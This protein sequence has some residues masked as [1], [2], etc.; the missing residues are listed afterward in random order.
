MKNPVAFLRLV[1]L[2][3]GISY[4]VLLGIAMP[5][6][7][8]AGRPQAVQVVGAIHGALFVVFGLALLR[9]WVATRWSIHR[10]ALVF[11]ASFIPFAPFWME[12][13]LRRWQAE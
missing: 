5:L 8:L 12:R 4:L 1:S 6:K 3:E 11:I 7:Y 13:R 2:A 10:P 9:A